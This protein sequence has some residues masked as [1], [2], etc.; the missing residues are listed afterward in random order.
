MSGNNWLERDPKDSPGLQRIREAQEA[1]AAAKAQ[2]GQQAR[3]AAIA[4]QEAER[5]RL[6]MI[7][8]IEQ[9]TA[10]ILPL[11]EEIRDFA[12]RNR[13]FPIGVFPDELV[14]DT[15][16]GSSEDM[17]ELVKSPNPKVV[18]PAVI[19]TSRAG[20]IQYLQKSSGLT[21][22]TSI[23]LEKVDTASQEADISV[24]YG[25]QGKLRR[26]VEYQRGDNVGYETEE[27]NVLFN[28][29]VRIHVSADGVALLQQGAQ[30]ILSH[31]HFG[32]FHRGG[33]KL[34]ESWIELPGN[35]NARKQLLAEAFHNPAYLGAEEFYIPTEPTFQPIE[36]Q[37]NTGIG[38]LVKG[39]LGLK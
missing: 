4:A 15:F 38:S 34:S 39:L 33:K 31:N 11:L 13:C 14:P 20:T 25:F 24:A 10:Q 19:F 30:G 7:A 5:K 6:E 28:Y 21:P 22:P 12:N 17:G 18:S 16:G 9:K 26:K 37:T 1:A 36:P 8:K 23:L 35:D 27:H 29:G 32:V 2:A 3:E